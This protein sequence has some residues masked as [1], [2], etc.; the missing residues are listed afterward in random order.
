MKRYPTAAERRNPDSTCPRFLTCSASVCPLMSDWRRT[1]Y[2]K[3][4]RGC[5]WLLELAKPG[6]EARVAAALPPDAALAV[7]LAFG[8]ISQVRGRSGEASRG[9]GLIRSALERAAR[10]PSR[11]DAARRLHGQELRP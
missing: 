5:T 2:L 9:L 11:L 10:T 8:A 6:G 1:R 4:E 7:S 3:G